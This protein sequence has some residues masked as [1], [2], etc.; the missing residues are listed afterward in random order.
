MKGAPLAHMRNTQMPPAPAYNSVTVS[1]AIFVVGMRGDTSGTMTMSG[2]VS[3]VR[4]ATQSPCLAVDTS[5]LD[6]SGTDAVSATTAAVEESVDDPVAVLHA[7]LDHFKK[8]HGVVGSQPKSSQPGF[9]WTSRVAGT[10]PGDSHYSSQSVQHV[11]YSD[12][13]DEPAISD[14]RPLRVHWMV[15][16]GALKTKFATVCTINEVSVVDVPAAVQ[17]L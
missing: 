15:T 8:C 12:R 7:R 16:L 2:N 13:Y 3:G 10:H 6:V 4:T 11:I 1:R 5:A 17:S 14:Q 9:I